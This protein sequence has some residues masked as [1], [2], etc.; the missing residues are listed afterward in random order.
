MASSDT[1]P[2][3][4]EQATSLPSGGSGSPGL[5]LQVLVLFLLTPGGQGLLV[6]AQRGWESWPHCAFIDSTLI[7][8]AGTLCSCSPC[9]LPW[10]HQGTSL[11][12]DGGGS[13]NSETTS[14]GRGQGAL[15]L[16]GGCRSPEPLWSSGTLPE[17]H[18]F[19]PTLP[20]GQDDY[21]GSFSSLLWPPGVGGSVLGCLI[22]V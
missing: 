14:A 22:T 19:P 18:S 11:P 8:G 6:T 3:R 12:L 15:F 2:A 13:P 21:P 4:E 9:G 20:P 7:G 5:G 16:L 1:N 17:G 10:H